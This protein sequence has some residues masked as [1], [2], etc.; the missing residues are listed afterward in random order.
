MVVEE[1]TVPASE[2]LN[3]VRSLTSFILQKRN[4]ERLKPTDFFKRAGGNTT[5]QPNRQVS[6]MWPRMLIWDIFSLWVGGGLGQLAH[7]GRVYPIVT[8]LLG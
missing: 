8:K 1:Q 5:L 7:S 3:T 4:K 6:V 2:G